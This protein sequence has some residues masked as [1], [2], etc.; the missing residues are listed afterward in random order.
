MYVCAVLFAIDV[1][2]LFFISFRPLIDALAVFL[3][4]CPLSSVFLSVWI[5]HDTLTMYL[6][7]YPLP[8][9]FFSGRP[10][11]DSITVS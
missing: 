11:L 2:P 4:V 6:I 8:S 1:R 9:E 10:L 5:L 3:I 7:V